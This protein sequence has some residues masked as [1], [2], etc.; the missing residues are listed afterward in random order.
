MFHCHI[1]EY[2]EAGLKGQHV[3]TQV[4]GDRRD[5]P[6]GSG[7]FSQSIGERVIVFVVGITSPGTFS[8]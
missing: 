2:E 4:A 8:A 3:C 1:P 5:P 6:K 7:G